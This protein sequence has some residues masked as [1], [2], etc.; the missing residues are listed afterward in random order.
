MIKK[1]HFIW[2]PIK[3]NFNKL[4]ELASEEIFDEEEG[5]V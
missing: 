4:D 3:E 1:G 2:I 5:G